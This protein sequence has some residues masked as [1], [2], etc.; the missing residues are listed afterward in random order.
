MGPWHQ[1]I[2][3]IGTTMII[4][5]YLA[6]QLGRLAST[7]LSYSTLNAIGASLLVVSLLFAYNLSA[8]IVEGFWVVISVVGIIRN[9]RARRFATNNS[10]P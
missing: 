2:G 6:L 9:I 4:G 5:S 8:L 1:W 3:I 10:S 7:D